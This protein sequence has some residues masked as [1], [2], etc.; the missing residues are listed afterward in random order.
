MSPPKSP[1]NI[2][3]H[4]MNG[5]E[6]I[7]E[8]EFQYQFNQTA[9]ARFDKILATHQTIAWEQMRGYLASHITGQ[10]ESTKPIAKNRSAQ[11]G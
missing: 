1:E 9:E 8:C 3:S 6:C 10:V 11:N 2:A 5:V 4:T 7:D